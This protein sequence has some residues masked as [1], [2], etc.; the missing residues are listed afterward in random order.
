MIKVVFFD[1]DGTLVSHTD[2]IVSESTRQS[3]K[4]LQEKG[5]QCVVATGRHFLEMEFLPVKDLVFDKVFD[6]YVALNGKLVCDKDRNIIY[7]NTIKGASKEALVKRFQ[8]MEKPTAFLE[9]DRIYINFSNEDAVRG[10]AKISSPVPDVGE[11]HGGEFFQAFAFGQGDFV[12]ELKELLP[13]CRVTTWC[14][15]AADI[16]D[17]QGSKVYGIQKYLE[18]IGVKPEETMAFGDGENDVEMLEFVQIGVAM[19]NAVPVA[20]EAA[21]YVTD[22]VDEDGIRNALIHYGLLEE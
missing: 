19:G 1:I 16:N 18:H 4:E 11:Y 14:D 21:D 15:W 7:K 20:K 2:T 17:A 3:I 13:G 12:E 5:I 10:Q 22:T 6:G 8:D 9:Y